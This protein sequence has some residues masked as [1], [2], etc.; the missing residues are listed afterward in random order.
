[1]RNPISLLTAAGIFLLGA[2]LDAAPAYA[3]LLSY[4]SSKGANTGN[5]ASPSAPCLTLQYALGQTVAGG[6]I[7]A[8]DAGN[9]GVISIT[10]SITITGVPGASIL[11]GNSGDAVTISA[12][13]NGIV[14]LRG[15][16]IDGLGV[17]LD[18]IRVNSA[19]SVTIADCVVRRVTADGIA[20]VPSSGSTTVIISNTLVSNNGNFG[21]EFVPSSPGVVKAT[22]S[23]TTTTNNGFA[24]VL[25]SPGATAM[26]VDSFAINNSIDGFR[27]SGAGAVMRLARSVATNNGTGVDFL[28]GS[29]VRSYG[30]NKIDGNGTDVSATIPIIPSR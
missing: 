26:I 19:A 16:E 20:V 21:I 11:R 22:V 4:V 10:K 2:A 30:D 27:A 23:Q 17:A 28:S 15:F 7:R 5:C 3:S 12:G 14:Y 25:V 9:F 18:G 6:Q 24:G 29:T 13:V 1:M 8:I